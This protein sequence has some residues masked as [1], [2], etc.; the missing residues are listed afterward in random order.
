MSSFVS[1]LSFMAVKKKRIK[2]SSEV[3]ERPIKSII[4]T[5]TWRVVASITTFFL[6]YFFFQDD[7]QATE[8]A[9][10]VASVEIFLKMFLY[11]V[12]ER[13]WNVV[14]WGKMRVY[15]RHYN[16]IRRRVIRRIFIAP[17]AVS[18]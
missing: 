16:M 17:T 15:V 5:I 13:A 9:T 18:D 3:R 6:A 8:K 7:P 2:E 4:K 11:F 1:L 14:R 12:H 10:G